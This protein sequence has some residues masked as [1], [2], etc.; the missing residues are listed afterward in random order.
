MDGKTG[1]VALMIGLLACGGGAE[2][3]TP[4]LEG[5]PPTFMEEELG[6]ALAEVRTAREGLEAG[7]PEAGESAEAVAS[8]EAAAGRLEGLITVYLPL[9][10]AKVATTNAYRHLEMDNLGEARRSIDDVEEGIL[11]ISR[12]TG[13]SIEAELEGVLEWVA[14]ARVALEAGSPEA[15]SHLRRLAETL[16]NL[17]TRAGLYME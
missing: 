12:S 2:G 16:D 13:G 5:T 11:A 17:L 4:V 9:Y 1:V 7:S 3:W 6:R 14:D 10:R 8:L 15:S